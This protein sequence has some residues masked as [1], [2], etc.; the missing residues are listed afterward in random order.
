MPQREI[1]ER[2]KERK[3]VARKGD[4]LCPACSRAVSAPPI[5][6]QW[7]A[8]NSALKKLRICIEFKANLG[9]ISGSLS[10]NKLEIP[11]EK[12]YTCKKKKKIKD[13]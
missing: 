12:K 13:L 11:Q 4:I 8:C 9:Y 1:D 5:K 6:V 10:Q 3:P 2:Q 7:H